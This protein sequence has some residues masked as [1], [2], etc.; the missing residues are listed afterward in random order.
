MEP[1][2][3]VAFRPRD[4][5]QS[6]NKSTNKP[7]RVFVAK[8]GWEGRF[9]LRKW[10]FSLGLWGFLRSVQ[11]LVARGSIHPR[12]GM[13]HSYCHVCAARFVSAQRGA[14]VLPVMTSDQPATDR[15]QFIEWLIEF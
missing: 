12:S 5:E 15:K 1:T 13:P 6:F 14:N 8:L 9:A 11:P 2:P 4:I 3:R 10:G 7:W